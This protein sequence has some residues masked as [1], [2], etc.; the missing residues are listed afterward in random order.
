MGAVE[1]ERVNVEAGGEGVLLNG[2]EKGAGLLDDGDTDGKKRMLD[3]EEA[4]GGEEG[5]CT[6]IFNGCDPNEP[7]ETEVKAVEVLVGEDVVR[8]EV[9]AMLGR[10]EVP[11][12]EKQFAKKGSRRALWI[13][14]LPA[15][16]GVTFHAGWVWFEVRRKVEWSYHAARFRC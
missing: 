2:G 4:V 13:R 14:C 9:W 12:N 8:R 16:A 1:R 11:K 5:F 6:E 10:G 15:R 7:E 3:M